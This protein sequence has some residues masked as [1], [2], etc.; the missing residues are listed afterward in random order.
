MIAEVSE[1]TKDLE[2]RC[3]AVRGWYDKSAGRPAEA[4]C[5][6]LAAKLKIYLTI[7][8]QIKK[9]MKEKNI[10]LSQAGGIEI[11]IGSELFCNKCK[12]MSHSITV[13]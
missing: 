6:K 3:S 2:I 13:I 7:P 8:D 5:N 12:Q 11:K 10:H 4:V 1:E 9:I